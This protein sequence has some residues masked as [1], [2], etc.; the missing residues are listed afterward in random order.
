M[1]EPATVACAGAMIL[2]RIDEGEVGP[3]QQVAIRPTLIVRAS[4]GAAV[5]GDGL[6]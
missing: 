6:V 3:V 5:S 4:C 1:V 2:D